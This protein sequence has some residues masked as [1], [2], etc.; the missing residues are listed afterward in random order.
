MS[1]ELRNDAKRQITRSLQEHGYPTYASLLQPFDIYLTDNPEVIGYMIPSKAK[2]VLNKYLSES[3]VSTIVRHEIMHEYLTHAQRADRLYK[4]DPSLIQ[5]HELSNIAADYEIS[6]KAYTDSDKS[7]ARAIRLGDKTL[8]G[9]VTEDQYPDWTEMS[10]EDMYCELAKQAKGQQQK[11]Q[12]LI[13]A[14]SELNQ[15]DLD[16]LSQQMD[17]S[18]GQSSGKVSDSASSDSGSPS[19]NSLG[20][21]SPSLNSD[22]KK[23]NSKTTNK[24]SKELDKQKDKLDDIES[25]GSS[26]GPFDSDKDQRDKADV[27][28]RVKQI[29][30]AFNKARQEKSLDVDNVEGKRREREKKEIRNAQ[31]LAKDPLHKFKINLDKFID[32]QT[33]EEMERSYRRF[34]PSYEDQGFIVPD[35]IELDDYNMPII[36][37]YW[38]VSG[39]FSSPEKTEGARK[40]IG[41]LNKYVKDDL[42]EMHTY[43]FADNVTSDLAKAGSG[44]SG[45]AVY[46]H[47]AA[48]KPTNV[49][50]ISDSDINQSHPLLK[51]PGAVWYL[52]FDT[53]A[54][55]FV[56]SV[57]GKK[58]TKS[59]LIT[60]Y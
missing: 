46:D 5:N 14:I 12:P 3:Q 40:A 15:Q 13:D 38:D 7:I 35:D 49:I 29:Q 39:S 52:F 37:V 6:N 17:D 58:Q 25:K 31:R 47:I 54:P 26:D 24:L 42:I 22:G 48:T 11:L 8:Q 41:T 2:I 9:L 45:E 55:L 4:S 20:N 32:E 44:T 18:S 21:S 57:R 59:Y 23:S 28:R 43:Y 27:A 30:D 33:S 53:D 51:V 50:I 19:D 1:T 10:F 36:N 34:N 60:N 16:D 56:E